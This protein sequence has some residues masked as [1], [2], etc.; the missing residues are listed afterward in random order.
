MTALLAALLLSATPLSVRVLEAERPAALQVPSGEVRCDGAGL[1]APVE[2]ALSE[3]R[4]RAGAT[5]CTEVSLPAGAAFSLAPGAPTYRFPGILHVGREL[6]V[7]SLVVELELEDYVAQAVRAAWPD[8]GPQAALEAQAVV[9]RTFALAGRRRHEARGYHL[10]DAEHCQRLAPSP[11]GPEARE[12]ARRTE[13]QVLLAGGVAL[14]P[15]RSHLACGGRT[16]ASEDVFGEA[17]P[18]PAVADLDGPGKPRCRAAPEV[19]WERTVPLEVLGAELR[20]APGA[21]PAPVVEVLRRDAAGS[22]LEVR[23]AGRRMTGLELLAWLASQPEGVALPSPRFTAASAEGEVRFTGSGV[24][25]GVGLCQAGAAAL[26]DRKRSA[27]EI[28]RVYFPGARL[29]PAP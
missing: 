24:G 16:S 10:C 23:V 22:V 1:A 14:R 19:R 12:A 3:K 29:A 9:A 11:A 7:L 20:A 6:T 4:L 21:S 2:V 27:P 26:A 13:G 15:A 8:G 17:G 28:L 25:H 5:P 18:G